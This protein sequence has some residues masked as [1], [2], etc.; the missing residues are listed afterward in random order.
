M[1]PVLQEFSG[2]TDYIIKVYAYS[3][4]T[5]VLSRD[6]IAHTVIRHPLTPEDVSTLLIKEQPEAII[7]ATSMHPWAL[8][9]EFILQARKL[10]IPCIAVLDFWSNYSMRFD[11][12]NGNLIIPDKIA[13][14]DKNAQTAMVSEGFPDESIII[15][16]Q[17]AFDEF[18]NKTFFRPEKSSNQSLSIQPIHILFVSQPIAQYYPVNSPQYPGYNE[19]TVL[20]SLV[21]FRKHTRYIGQIKIS[22]ILHPTHN[23]MHFEDFFQKDVNFIADEASGYQ[24][25]QNCDLIC[26]M[27]S[28][29]LFE[30]FLMSIPVF[31][32]QPGCKNPFQFPIING[33]TIPVFNDQEEINMEL[34]KGLFEGS[35]PVQNIKWETPFDGKATQRVVEL[36]HNLLIPDD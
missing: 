11:D 25:I 27:T 20:Q 26:G 6:N 9:K 24:A 19:F 3:A 31:S 23:E 33:Q 29:K 13:V 7:T 36:I 14:M 18:Y 32:L 15:T 22:V 28:T 35:F 16:G 10:S 30:S 17:P 34:E 4:S 8:E 5:K 2:L 21:D 1:S 12:A